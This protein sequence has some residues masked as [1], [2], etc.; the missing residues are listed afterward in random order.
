V[1]VQAKNIEITY[2]KVVEYKNI[3]YL[4]GRSTTGNLYQIANIKDIQSRK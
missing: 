1:P 3:K 4:I 2:F